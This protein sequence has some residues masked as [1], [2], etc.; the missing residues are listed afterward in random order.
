MSQQNGPVLVKA[1][2]L[3]GFSLLSMALCTF[4]QPQVN[5]AERELEEITVTARKREERLIDVP[6]SAAVL[7]QEEIE[8]YRTLSL[9]HI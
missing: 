7:T 1:K 5:A 8:R 6:V 3:L 4:P 9:I 2:E